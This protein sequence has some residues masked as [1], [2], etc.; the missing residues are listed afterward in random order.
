MFNRTSNIT[1]Y[2]AGGGKNQIWLDKVACSGLE[3]RLDEC[4]HAGWGHHNCYHAKDVGI[5]CTE[6]YGGTLFLDISVKRLSDWRNI[7]II[8]SC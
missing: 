2:K 4:N 8:I 5:N 1:F 7:L 3:R 6:E